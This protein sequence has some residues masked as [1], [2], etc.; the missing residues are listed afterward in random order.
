MG[1]WVSGF[2]GSGKSSFAK[3]LGL[4]IADRKI[5][6]EGAAGILAELLGDDRGSV[7]LNQIR[8]RMPTHAAIFDV[9]T[10]RGISSANQRLSEIMYRVFLREL[11][12]PNDLDLAELEI[13][14]EEDGRLDEFTADFQDSYGESWDRT[15]HRVA[16]AMSQA[17]Q[18]MH[19]LDPV[20]F[21]APGSWM[22]AARGRGDITPRTLADRCRE[23]TARRRPGRR[24]LFVIDEV[25][26]FVARDHQKMLDL[27]AIV[28][29]LGVVGR[30]KIW[31]VVTSQERLNDMVGGLDDSRVELQRLMDR[32]PIQVH[33]EQ[34][35]IAEITS[36]R[37]LQK[38]ASGEKV[39][40]GLF[41]ANRGRLE[42]NTTI[43]ADVRLPTLTEDAFVDLYPLLPY[44]VDLIIRIVSGLR[45]QGG[46]NRHVGGAN[47]TIIKLAQQL[48]VHPQ[49]GLG[50]RSV[51]ALAPLDVIYDLVVSNI[52]SELRD[53]IGG[54]E[55]K[56]A[57]PWAE[58]VAK[59]VCLLQFVKSVHRTQRNLAALLHPGVEADSCLSEVEGAVSALV[60]A[61]R[62]REG[63]DGIRI[64]TE[65]EN[66]WERERAGLAATPG[67]VARLHSAILAESWS[68]A[69]SHAL[70]ETRTF[71]AGLR[72]SG[73]SVAEGEVP[74]HVTLVASGDDLAGAVETARA[75][76][77][78]E[79]GVFWV[80]GLE[81][82][83][84]HQAEELFRSEEML[85]R[86]Q[87]GARTRAQAT[88]VDEEKRRRQQHR[89]ELKRLIQ[90]AML[91]GS[92]FFRGR[93][94]SPEA[95][96]PAVSSAAS[97]ILGRVLPDEYPSFA[98]GAA[99]VRPADLKSLLQSED[100]RGLP[101]VFARLDL[102]KEEAGLPVFAT[103]GGPLHEYSHRS[104]IA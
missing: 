96:A 61:G 55:S 64:P 82:A 20:T 3:Y 29:R 15:K 40:R 92:A 80:A 66:L 73:R 2:F 78:E 104:A 26:Q 88:L 46:A 34:S 31:L 13:Q 17:S 39:L 11:G 22:D 8:E 27:Q 23:L 70:H 93:E 14:L 65:S 30:G 24:L 99:K 37:V 49:C 7:L 69:P 36:R 71:R 98:Q 103:D 54:I 18:V 5:Q 63:S 48:I 28:Q 94:R 16:F 21:P 50:D 76:S 86:R 84:E 91:T 95:G 42:Q 101:T 79:S 41:R 89:E 77:R 56:V 67:D 35:D 19:R 72:V 85:V 87:R 53:T 59:A 4:A 9:S 32:F 90:E 52:P 43:T 57:H 45:T 81:E 83:A 62:L 58:R 47:R 12:Y 68:P 75:R 74:F 10:D 1:I 102:L 33:L 100:L 60:G 51:G 25:G 6:G 38:S 44:Q 97:E